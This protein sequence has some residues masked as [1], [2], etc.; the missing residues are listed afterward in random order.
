MLHPNAAREN[1]PAVQT[2][3]HTGEA[4]KLHMWKS[5]VQT[6]A[7]DTASPCGLEGGSADLAGV[8]C[9]RSL[10]PLSAGVGTYRRPH[11]PSMACHWSE[12]YVRVTAPAVPLTPFSDGLCT[13]E[14]VA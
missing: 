4:P 14:G 9:T 12:E 6:L 13:R 2:L 10:R 3:L 7:R 5:A 1:R 8:H 11:A